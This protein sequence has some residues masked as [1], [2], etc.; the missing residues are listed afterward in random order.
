M[1]RKKP[2]MA[3]R[4]IALVI[5]FFCSAPS[6]SFAVDGEAIAENIDNYFIPAYPDIYGG[7]VE[8]F[9]EEEVKNINAV[10]KGLEIFGYFKSMLDIS[11]KIDGGD[12]SGATMDAASA[13]TKVAIS[14]MADETTKKIIIYG[15]GVSALPLT[16]LVTSIDIARA[17]SKAVDDSKTALDLERLYYRIE[18][19]PALKTTGRK[20]GEGDPIR[21][22]QQAVERIWRQIYTDKDFEGVFKTYVTTELGQEWPEPTLWEKITISSDY[23]REAKLLEDQKRIKGYAVGLLNELNKVAQKRET[24]VIVAKQLKEIAATG[25]AFSEEELQKAFQAYQYAL[26]R[27]PDVEKY[28]AAFVAKSTDLKTRFDKANPVQLTDIKKEII[29]EQVT[30]RMHAAAVR[31]FPTVGKYAATRTSTLNNLKKANSDLSSLYNAIPQSEIDKR[32]T[33]QNKRIMQDSAA[34][35][36]AGV[37][38]AFTRYECKKT[39]DD[40]KGQFFDKVMTGASDAVAS[41]DKAKAE[42]NQN[43]ADIS[44]KYSKDLTEN[45]KKYDDAVQRLAEQTKRVSDAYNQTAANSPQ[46][47]VLYAELMRLQKQSSD[48]QGRYESYKLMT[49]STAQIDDET[50]KGAIKEMDKFVEANYNRFQITL[51][52]LTEQ[53]N[54]AFG[55]IQRFLDNHGTGKYQGSYNFLSAEEIGALK[56]MI[57]EAPPGYAGMDLKFLKDYVKVDKEKVLSRSIVDSVKAIKDGLWKYLGATNGMRMTYYGAYE[58][59]TLP[60]L[61]FMESKEAAAR[62][63]EVLKANDTAVGAIEKTDQRQIAA[64]AKQQ[65]ADSLAALKGQRG[66]MEGYRKLISMASG[67]S[68][69][70]EQYIARAKVQNASVTEDS[71]Y[72]GSLWSQVEVARQILE[73]TIVMSS[74]D[75]GRWNFNLGTT[76]PVLSGDSLRKALETSNM[77]DISKK[78]GLGLE[79]MIPEGFVEVKAKEGFITI[80]VQDVNSLTAKITSIPTSDLTA[81]YGPMHA[82][83]K[84]TGAEGFFMEG[85]F[86]LGNNLWPLFSASKTL[87]AAGQNLRDTIAKQR[88]AAEKNQGV[89]DNDNA[90]FGIILNRISPAVAAVKQYISQG[91]Y[92]NAMVYFTVRDDVTAQ[93]LAFGRK[94][95]DVDTALKELADL[96][97]Q[98]KTKMVAGGPQGQPAAGLQQPMQPMQGMQGQP[99]QAQPVQPTP[100]A[101]PV[102]QQSAVPQGMPA[103]GVQQAGVTEAKVPVAQQPVTALPPAVQATVPPAV[104][105]AEP[106]VSVMPAPPAV[107][108]APVAVPAPPAQPVPAVTA[109]AAPAVQPPAPAPA[110]VIQAESPKQVA[111]AQPAALTQEPVTKPAAQPETV[112]APPPQAAS[113]VIQPVPSAVA[114]AV[115]AASSQPTQALPA[116]LAIASQAAPAQEQA[117]PVPPSPQV[118]AVT[119]KLQ[120]PVV[121][122]PPAIPMAEPQKAIPEAPA[123]VTI[124]APP[125]AQPAPVAI[126][127][128]PAQ[129]V[130]AVTASAPPAAPAG[131]SP[132]PQAESPRQVA[133]SQPSQVSQEPAAQPAPAATPAPATV[134]AAT[135]PPAQ[136]PAPAVQPAAGTP[137]AIVPPKASE[138]VKVVASLPQETKTPIVQAAE[139][140]E[141]PTPQIRG[142]YDALKRGYESKSIAGFVQSV[143]PKWQGSGGMAYDALLRNVSQTFRNYDDIRCNIQGLRIEKVSSD[144]YRASYDITIS[145]KEKKTKTMQEERSAVAEEIAIEKNGKPKIAKT[146]T[147]RFWS[148]K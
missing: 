35:A 4:I 92:D 26:I 54:N 131:V 81:F 36:T 58:S 133:P 77:L 121:E 51:G 18:A 63:E 2:W 79:T 19:D 116:P 119:P 72:V 64:T 62:V 38:F 67:L 16:L 112:A 7:I 105:A 107:Q 75:A 24:A 135:Q 111:S 109:S 127:A 132:A 3:T 55:I 99:V 126:P 59:A 91:R 61:K 53:Y 89:I 39:F 103:Q 34:F 25:A 134:A 46:K 117:R 74:V 66:V 85:Y 17:S 106:A 5:L 120:V 73:S 113:P 14:K 136:A 96:I 95:A 78:L 80:R 125:A 146:V 70:M 65:V 29:T 42:V 20:L 33:D 12:Y 28:L 47:A 118:A 87:E 147:G 68:A 8:R 60:C 82:M 137:A 10:L 37:D 9:P 139:K 130:P 98:A 15:V 21:H 94:R 41:V 45:Q 50:C 128:S 40:L 48:L 110:P 84:S 27:L 88:A 145:G 108:P 22:D 90:M 115:V 144:K 69:A 129:P 76:P 56:K 114:G 101:Q 71:S 124:S 13:I 1:N 83:R 6:A 138:P 31:G 100:A 44:Q 143:S 141:D 86:S 30:I 122:K 148:T 32:L 140:V 43:L 49:S 142:L 93:Y 123:A 23:L 97:E 11:L 52:S 102:V 104:R 57:A